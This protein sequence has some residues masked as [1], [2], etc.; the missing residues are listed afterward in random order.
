M[1]RLP[2][3]ESTITGHYG[4]MSAYRKKHGLQ[5]HSGTDFAPKGSNKGKTAIPAVGKGTVQFVKWSNVLGWVLVQTIWDAKKR[6]A[7]YVGYC[8]LSCNKC[9]INCPGGHDASLAI[10]LTADQKVAEGQTIGIMGNTGSATSGVHLHLTLSDK[11]RG[12][13]GITADKECFIEWLKTQAPAKK[14]ADT[15]DKAVV[16]QSQ[17]KIVYACPHCKKEL[18]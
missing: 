16:G 12:V 8:H 13:F 1:P 7:K 4:T 5:P 15:K 3:P 9:G 10:S 6:K 14:Q 18:C 11:E 17:S 2:F